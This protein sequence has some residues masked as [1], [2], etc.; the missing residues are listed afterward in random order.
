[1][2]KIGTREEVYNGLA[3]KTSGGMYKDDI[4]KIGNVSRGSK[5]NQK[6]NQKKNPRLN[7][8]RDKYISKKKSEIMKGK[9]RKSMKKEGSNTRKITFDKQIIM[10]KYHCNKMDNDDVASGYSDGGL[11]KLSCLGIM[12]D[13]DS[14]EL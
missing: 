10:R 14:L 9:Y 6:L 2:K 11:S 7:H 13:L 1:M 3:I 8:K 12:K 4:I 5:S